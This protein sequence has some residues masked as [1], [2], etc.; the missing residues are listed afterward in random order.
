MKKTALAIVLATLAAPTF[1]QGGYAGLGFGQSSVDIEVDTSLSSLAGVT[2]TVEDSDTSFK[3]FAG[4]NFNDNFGVE[5]AYQNLGE[6]SVRYED[7][8]DFILDTWEASALS[9]AGIGYLPINESASVFGKFGLARW[10][11]DAAETSSIPGVAG[12]VSESGIDPLFG[13]G[14]QY[15][16]GN[17]ALRAEYERYMSLGDAQTT[18]ESDV[19]VIGVSAALRF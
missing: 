10:D 16:V 3:L 5:V 9:V 2:T 13:L 12:G 8:V 17:V 18:G 1:A 6:M 11:L 15:T 7:S 19:D 4:Y 14:F